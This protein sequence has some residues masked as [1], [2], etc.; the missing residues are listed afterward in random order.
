MENRLNRVFK[1]PI[2]PGFYP[3]PTI[4]RAGQDFYLATS[5]FEYFPG[6]PLFHSRDL[7]HWRQLGHVLTR[8]SQLQLDSVASSGG[9]YAPT[10]RYHQG[11][12]YLITSHIG[13]GGNFIVTATD[14]AGPWSDPMWLGDCGI[15]PSLLFD[16]DDV[17]YTRNGPGPDRDHPLLYQARLDLQTGRLTEEPR[18][19]WAGTGGIWPEGSHLY[20]R[21]GFYYLMHAEGGTSYGHREVVARSRSAW[22]PF[23]PALRNPILGHERRRGHAI[24]ATGHADLVTLPDGSLWAVMLGVRPQG[25]RY[26]HLGR[27]TF[28]APARWDEEGWPVI[29]QEGHIEELMSAPPLPH[30]DVPQPQVRED[31]CSDQLSHVWNFVRNPRQEHWSVTERPGFLRLWGAAETIGDAAPIAL[32]GRRQQHF[33]VTARARLLFEPAQAEEAGLVV[34]AN[35]R[36]Y[37]ALLVRRVAGR[38]GGREAVL[39]A[40]FRGKARCVARVPLEEGPVL[41]EMQGTP[42]RYIFR[43][44]GEGSDLLE[45][46]ERPARALAAE[47][48]MATGQNYFTGAYLCM[49]ASGAGQPA[50]NPADFDWFDYIVDKG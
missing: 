36:F 30:F 10:L 17:Y 28:L 16:G 9:I 46:D 47:T 7:V 13:G 12:F 19:I 40:G 29:G 50:T 5:S 45:L 21:G 18:P 48:V 44:G 24:Q 32:L 1:N 11:T 6:V 20:K 31:F 34:R 35:E 49:Y 8:R 4:C 3:D 33:E 43:A 25:G 23:Q 2:L 39:V 42:N 15:D 37:Y 26:H 38:G 22:G 27:E 14:P 41:L